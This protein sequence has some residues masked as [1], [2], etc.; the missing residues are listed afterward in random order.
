MANPVAAPV[1]SPVYVSPITSI[2]NHLSDISIT[3]AVSTA[4]GYGITRGAV[5]IDSAWEID[6]KVGLITGA[7]IGALT[8]LFNGEGANKSS[9]LLMLAAI[10]I[11]PYQLCQYLQV[12]TTVKVIAALTLPIFVSLCALSFIAN[13]VLSKS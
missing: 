10:V 4:I 2:I 5:F 9:A 13:K 3:T 8:G 6:P 11:V 7:A 1:S 12:P